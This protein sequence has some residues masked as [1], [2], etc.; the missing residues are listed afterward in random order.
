MAEKNKRDPRET[1]GLV[2][3]VTFGVITAIK[4]AVWGMEDQLHQTLVIAGAMLA[5]AGLVMWWWWMKQRQRAELE[6]R[7][8]KKPAGANAGKVCRGCGTGLAGV[9]P[10]PVNI[11]GLNVERAVCPK[12]GRVA[13]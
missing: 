2:T 3:A 12:C 8:R 1:L 4:I 10:K 6:G 11:G 13:A 7:E 5:A 9:K